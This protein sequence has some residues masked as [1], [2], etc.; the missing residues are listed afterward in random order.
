MKK[1]SPKS[2]IALISIL[3]IVT[4]VIIIACGW[5]GEEDP[6]YS[7]LPQELIYTPFYKTSEIFYVGGQKDSNIHDFDSINIEEWGGFF[8]GL[9]TNKDLGY[10]LYQARIGEIDTLIYFLKDQ[11]FPLKTKLALNTILSYP[12][13]NISMQFLVY[14]RFAK[15]CETF[16]TYIFDSSSWYASTRSDTYDNNYFKRLEEYEASVDPRNNKA[17]MDQIINDGLNQLVNAKNKF[18]YERYLFQIARLYYHAKRYSD[19]VSFYR[20]NE[21]QFIVSK[22]IKYRTL[23]YAAGSLY[24]SKKFGESNYLYSLLYDQY[25][26]MEDIAYVGFSPREEKDLKQSLK[27]AKTDREK[28]VIWQLVGIHADP[29]RGMKE[30]YKLDPK[31]DLLYVLL[32]RAVAIAEKSYFP[33]TTDPTTVNIKV[34]KINNDLFEFVRKT[35]EKKNT[36]K[37]YVWDLVA[38]YFSFVKSDFNDARAYFKKVNN[39]VRN[40]PMVEGQLHLLN[41][42]MLVQEN[43]HPDKNFENAIA[44]DLRWLKIKS[45]NPY[46]YADYPPDTLRYNDIYTW[47]LKKLSAEYLAQGDTIKSELLNPYMSS[48]IYM[49]NS[50]AT[51]MFA[52]MDKKDK[53]S[54]DRLALSV[55]KYK[56]VDI[57]EY[58]GVKIF[59]D[60]NLPEAYKIFTAV[61]S[62]GT[63]VLPADPFDIHINDNHDR[64]FEAAKKITYTKFTFVK[65]MAELQASI[66]RKSPD[67]ADL[68]FQLANG[69]YNSTYFGNNR[70]FYNT[71]ITDYYFSKRHEIMLDTENIDHRVFVCSNALKYYLKAMELSNDR[72]FKAKCCFMAAKCE[73]NK[74]FCRKDRKPKIDFVAG[75]YFKELK[76]SY[77]NTDYYNEIIKECGY[78]RTY[79]SK[80]K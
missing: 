26:E 14:L 18:I 30:I 25:P 66:D 60:G 45:I 76:D 17:N 10:I 39:E 56:K 42:A 71:N 13:K 8:S 62:V 5:D 4:T 52:F 33:L 75:K 73:Q 46:G 34:K 69:F 15:R 59:L 23:G 70:T 21:P 24:K 27:L 1:I 77:N 22:S 20:K 48:E 55:Y 68:C 7:F 36:L 78:F 80:N 72:D 67:A 41:L 54:F 37:Q 57:L 40:N 3:I 53:S 79:L 63:T 2:I 47:I 74:Y 16:T 49:S 31:S 43:P 35:A 29:L 9:V 32:A 51:K 58:Q 19:C 38:G 65:R 61:D 50:N 12:D 28:E 6:A 11:K 64:D 44:K